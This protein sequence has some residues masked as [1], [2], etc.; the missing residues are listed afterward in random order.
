MDCKNTYMQ[1]RTISERR[2][3]HGTRDPHSILRHGFKAGLGRV[4]RD[5]NYFGSLY[6]ALAYG[7]YTIEVELDD[8]YI[9]D[10][11][12]FFQVFDPTDSSWLRLV[13]N[14]PPHLAPLL[15][16]AVMA[17]YD[18]GDNRALVRLIK[19]YNLKL[20]TP[21]DERHSGTE[22]NIAYPSDVAVDDIVGAYQLQRLDRAAYGSSNFQV[23]GVL[24]S[25]GG[26]LSVGDVVRGS[27]EKTTAGCEPA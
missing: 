25:N 27:N 13:R 18:G 4:K 16:D 24:Y 20:N 8:N 5:N 26:T 22:A 21:Y 23:T 15:Q 9:A 3:F 7:Q 6:Q 12:A 10:E 11:D 14:L 2:V 1:L 19:Q 17:Y